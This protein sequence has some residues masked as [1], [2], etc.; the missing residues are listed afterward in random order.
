[1]TE[2]ETTVGT[3]RGKRSATRT[4][5][6]RGPATSPKQAAGAGA[7]RKPEAAPARREAATPSLLE[8]AVALR[9]AIQRSKLTAT[10]PWGYTAKARGW[11]TRAEQLVVRIGDDVETAAAR[12]GVEALRAEVEGDRDFREARRLF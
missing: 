3:K 6:Q 10:D 4:S 8:Q 5:K 1:V 12:K 11:L 7:R 2:G 9:D